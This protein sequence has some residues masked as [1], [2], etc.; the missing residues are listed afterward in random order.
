[1][2]ALDYISMSIAYL[3]NVRAWSRYWHIN[4]F[5]SQIQ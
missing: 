1:M 5:L 4:F 2:K 3:I